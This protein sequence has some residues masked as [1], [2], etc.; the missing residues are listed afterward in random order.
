MKKPP[1]HLGKIAKQYWR[2]FAKLIDVTDEN[3]H[4]L[5][6]LCSAC[7]DYRSAE[8][9]LQTDGYLIQTAYA[10]RPH[11]AVSIKNNAVDQI[12]RLT[13]SLFTIDKNEE[14]FADLGI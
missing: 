6:V 3:S 13:S 1:T 10:T 5:A 8:Q 2:H 7:E 4:M 12:R 14:Q 9:L 11:P